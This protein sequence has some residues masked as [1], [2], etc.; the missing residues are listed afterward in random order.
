MISNFFS[1]SKP[2]HYIIVSVI[3]LVVFVLSR[4]LVV[5][6]DFSLMFLA[7]QIGLFCVVILSLFVFDFLVRRNGLT[8][9]NSYNILL[10][11]IFIAIFPQTLLNSRILFANFFILLALRRIIS[12]RSQK[13][14]KKKLFDASF[15]IALATLFYFWASVFFIMIFAALLVYLIADV[16]NY[17]IPFVGVAAAAILVILYVIVLDKDFSAVTETML[18]YSLDFS[19]LNTKR[20]VVGLAV[21]LSIGLWSMFYY[22][23]NIKF[24]MKS[25]RPSFKLIILYVCL[26]VFIIAVAP[27]KNGSEFIFLFVP[28]SIVITNYIEVVSKKWLKETLLLVMILTPIILLML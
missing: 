17:L 8:K 11:A 6:D 12:L 26:G 18:A 21:L 9:K 22:I 10:F 16:K 23:K 27:S 14:I 28:L 4:L 24:Q 3:L 13:D 7:N 1:K 2:I 20:I 19:T 5:A 15:W 25:H